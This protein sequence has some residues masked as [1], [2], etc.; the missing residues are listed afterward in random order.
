[1]S[2]CLLYGAY[3]MQIVEGNICDGIK[4]PIGV[5]SD[6]FIIADVPVRF[7]PEPGEP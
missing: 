1:M 2:V 5:V 4:R 7:Q 6:T 3:Y